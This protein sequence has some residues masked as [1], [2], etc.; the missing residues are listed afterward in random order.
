MSYLAESSP[1]P[2]SKGHYNGRLPGKKPGAW[3]VFPLRRRFEPC[4][5]CTVSYRF[6]GALPGKM[7][8]LLIGLQLPSRQLNS[9]LWKLSTVQFSFPVWTN[10][11]QT[12]LFNS[13]PLSSLLLSLPND[14]LQ[15]S[16][17]RNRV[18]THIDLHVSSRYSWFLLSVT[19]TRN[20][21]NIIIRKTM[22]S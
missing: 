17:E 15:W 6:Y 22:L 14:F 12:F 4:L 20:H 13:F 2:C 3:C 8:P 1:L 16:L 11:S 21:W 18:A 19:T 5:L 9:A 10:N 7:A